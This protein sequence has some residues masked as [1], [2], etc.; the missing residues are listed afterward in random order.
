MYKIYTKG[1]YFIIE[2]RNQIF[3]GHRKN[4]FVDKNNL[5]KPIYRFF[6]ITDWK[7]SNSLHI[8]EIFK[9]DS[10][11]YTELEFD[12]FYRQNTGNFNGGSAFDPQYSVNNYSELI[13]IT[14]TDVGQIA[15]VKNSQG[16]KWLP[17]SL[18]GTY[19]PE[20]W[21]VWNGT[22]WVSDRN[23]ISAEL[24][25]LNDNKFNNPTGT[26][27]DYLDGTGTPKPFPT[28]P[29]LNNYVPYNGA[30]QNVNLG[31]YS[32]Q[33]GQLELDETPTGLQGE[34]I[35]RW[36]DVEGTATIGLKG[37]SI[38]LKVG[39]DNVRRVINKST[40]T[41]LRTDYKIVRPRYVS[42]GG[43]INSKLTVDLAKADN[44]FNSFYTLGVAVEDINV[45]QEGFILTKG[46]VENINTTG[47][48]QSEVWLDGDVLYLSPY[49]FGEL[50]KV[51]P[52]SPLHSVVIGFVLNAHLTQGRLLVDINR[53][54]EIND[55]HDVII[56]NPI[57]GQ[58]LQYFSGVWEN[59]FTWEYLVNNYSVNPI[60]L[61]VSGGG[62]VFSYTLNGVT[63]YRFVPNA[64][65][66]TLDA[67]YE[68]LALT[69][70][71][72]TRG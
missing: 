61:G 67:F 63:R 40:S 20:G 5:K 4:V 71:I 14:P 50:T 13:L 29:N 30:L 34:R 64:Y 43:T 57:D 10:S 25:Y 69:I 58:Q 27:T 54:Y 62:K 45:D 60:F 70:L 44:N 46:I 2:D 16:T 35:I 41:L 8:S 52:A 38:P 42:E 26:I 36:D 24:Q 23:D 19:Y 56:S 66:P 72:V 32:L 1:N 47:S 51:K 59:K 48:I 55:L 37:G 33:A 9:E 65:D 11:P 53:G 17:W 22:N 39:Q 12:T 28:I 18:G 15:Y 49:N 21:Y 31:E 7:T 6:N 3:Y 68:D